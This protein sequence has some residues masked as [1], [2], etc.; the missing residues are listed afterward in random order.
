MRQGIV[1]DLSPIPL[2]ES[3][4]EQQQGTLGL[5]EVGHDPFHQLE[6]IARCDDDLCGSH[7]LIG[8]MAI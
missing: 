6:R 4:D 5:V 7:Q 3:G 2:H 1:V 8:L